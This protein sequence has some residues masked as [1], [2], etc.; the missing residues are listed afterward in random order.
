MPVRSFALSSVW[1]AATRSSMQGSGAAPDP[2]Q[3]VPLPAPVTVP[4]GQMP[5]SP[6]WHKRRKQPI[7]DEE[8]EIPAYKLHPMDM[9]IIREAA[10]RMNLS[11]ADYAQIAPFLYAKCMVEFGW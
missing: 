6:T 2:N 9:D 4:D 8:M 1:Y 7:S 10:D 11:V 5:D 3:L